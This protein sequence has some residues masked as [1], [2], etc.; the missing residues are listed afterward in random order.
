MNYSWQ[1]ETSRLVCRWSLPGEKTAYDLSWLQEFAPGEPASASAIPNF[2]AHS[3]LGSGEWFA[4]WNARW[5]V[6][7]RRPL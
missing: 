3:S 2:A 5:S 7:E 1:S 6:P 4:S